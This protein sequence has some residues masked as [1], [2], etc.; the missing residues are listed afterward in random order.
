MVV[1]TLRT[2]DEIDSLVPA[3]L[4]RALA[5]HG[6]T[7]AFLFG[8]SGD[9][10]WAARAPVAQ[11]ELGLLAEALDLLESL[12]EDHQRPFIGHDEGGR[13]VVAALD[14]AED[15][16]V[17]VLSTELDRLAAEARVVLMREELQTV[18][19]PLR[20]HFA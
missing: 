1:V 5:R 2:V 9:P 19:E 17:V 13:F 8:P 4:K 20:Q 7:Q 12:E 14:A 3:L 15:A 16:Y 18:T 11:A 10:F 6:G